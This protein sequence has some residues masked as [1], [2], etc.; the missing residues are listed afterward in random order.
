M[1]LLNFLLFISGNDKSS[2]HSTRFHSL[3]KVILSTILFNFLIMTC[4]IFLIFISIDSIKVRSTI[5]FLSIIINSSIMSWLNLTISTCEK[6][7]QILMSSTLLSNISRILHELQYDIINKQ[8]SIY[9]IP[10]YIFL[11]SRSSWWTFIIEIVKR[12]V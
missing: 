10:T 9:N 2:W 4:I 5:I 3:Y 1:L 6:W 7:R 8:R 11:T 12:K